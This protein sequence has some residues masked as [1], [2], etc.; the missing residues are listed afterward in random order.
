M[1]AVRPGGAHRG[2]SPSPGKYKKWWKPRRRSGGS[3][4]GWGNK[5]VAEG[6]GGGVGPAAGADLAVEIGDVSRHG[7]LAD[8]QGRRNLARALSRGNELE[9]LH[10]AGREP[11]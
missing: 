6:V 8:H 10:F 5:L 4:V 7:R 3:R 2:N 1:V 11:I 9:H